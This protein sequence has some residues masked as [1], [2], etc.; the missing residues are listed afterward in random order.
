MIINRSK[1]VVP[2][3]EDMYG[4]SCTSSSKDSSNKKQQFTPPE[5]Q[6]TYRF[7]SL[8][9]FGGKSFVSVENL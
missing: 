1:W 8:T 7:Q 9:F 2:V 3:N 4:T 5:N 6:L